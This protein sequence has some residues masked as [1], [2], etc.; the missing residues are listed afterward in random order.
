MVFYNYLCMTQSS[1]DSLYINIAAVLKQE[2][3]LKC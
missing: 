3:Q 1:P 2:Q